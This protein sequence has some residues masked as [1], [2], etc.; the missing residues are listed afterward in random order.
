[1][2]AYILILPWLEIVIGCCLILGLFPKIF[3]GICIPVVLSFIGA[4][5]VWYY[6]AL[7]PSGC[8]CFGEMLTLPYQNALIIDADN[9]YSDIN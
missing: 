8:G 6:T 7:H 9:G 3:S 1:M 2:D 5:A 4:N